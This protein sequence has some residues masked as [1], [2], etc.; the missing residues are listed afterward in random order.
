MVPLFDQKLY[1]LADVARAAGVDYSQVYIKVKYNKTLTG[2]SV[3]LGHR[4]FYNEEDFKRVVAECKLRMRSR[5]ETQI[6]D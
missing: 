6:T 4:L 5:Y 1:S 3:E 2:P